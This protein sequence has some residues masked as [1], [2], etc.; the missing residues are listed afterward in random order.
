MVDND[1]I[2]IGLDLSRY[3]LN[4]IPMIKSTI[5]DKKQLIK[6]VS[7]KKLHLT[8]SFL[9]QIELNQIKL[10]D[11]ELKQISSCNS[12]NITVN[13]TGTFSYE[14]FPRVLWLGINE[15]ESELKI[16]QKNIDSIALPFKEK[17]KKEK[18]IP[19]I[20]IGRIKSGKNFDLSTFSNAVYSDI[21]IPIKRVYLFKSQLL[22]KGVEYS[23][24]SEYPLK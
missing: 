10:L 5:N 9:G 14:D 20:T 1:R 18:F 16:L 2:F 8:L 21:K 17:N 11:A 12:F 4:T 13:G 3:F 23:T 19:H 24:I 7:G 15:G 6:W 22:E